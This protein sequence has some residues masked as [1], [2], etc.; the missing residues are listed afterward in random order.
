MTGVIENGLAPYIIRGLAEAKAQGAAAVVLDLDTPGGRVD[1]AQRIV[2]AVRASPVPVHAWVHPRA[3]SAG[4]MI[5]LAARD[6][7]IAPGGIIGAATPVLGEGQRA[8]EKI[9]S[10]MRAEFRALA[11]QRGLD[12]RLAEAMVD[13][14]VEL[15]G[16]KPKGKLLTL[17]AAEAVRLG[18]ARG[19]AAD[20]AALLAAI[21]Q[22]GATVVDVPVN[23][24][25][26]IV[27]FLT[28]PAVSPLLLSLG[29]I[30]LVME[31]KAGAFGLGGMLSVTSLGL[32]FGSS[33][34]LGLAGW[35]ELIL[36][37]VGL[38]A[39]VLELFVLPGFGIAGLIG[40]AS[41]T[42]AVILAMTGPAPAMGEL[43]QAVGILGV[44]LL[45][46]LGVFIAWL[47]HLPNSDRFRRALLLDTARA[48]DGFVA[49]LPR[50]DLVGRRG[51]A[52]TD[53]RPSGAATVEGE[54]LD[55]VTE[56]EYVSNGA[57][58]EVVRSEGYRH[59]V[60]AAG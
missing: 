8:P 50:A 31:I 16:V 5:A 14:D 18:V 38:L 39:L 58:V 30:G 7:H 55:V 59:V 57:A 40:I 13:E 11:E 10:A 3:L 32:F 51:T 12:P 37:G 53:L 20:E 49:A 19:E 56:G 28:H 41:I 33:W 46:T 24:A 2:D 42:G 48:E 43:M 6:V 27:R 25:E 26:K 54:R 47:R 29:M 23:W 15:P 60:R 17:S 21:G 22:P 1:A 52:V 36:L 34:V 44:S 4:A 45:F 9:V 35:E